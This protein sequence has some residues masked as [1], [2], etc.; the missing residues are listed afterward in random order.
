MFG[1]FNIS[2]YTS[3]S[4]FKNGNSIRINTNILGYW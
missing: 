3:K 4:L 1:N 2:F